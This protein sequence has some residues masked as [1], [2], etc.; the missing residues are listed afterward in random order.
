MTQENTTYTQT[1]NG[2]T[3]VGLSSCTLSLSG[4]YSFSVFNMS[5]YYKI[6]F[7]KIKTVK[8][9]KEILKALDITFSDTCK[10]FD[11]IKKYLKPE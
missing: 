6:D 3:I 5:K 4:N 1:I 10:N 2:Q 7:D 9:I 11:N 8:D